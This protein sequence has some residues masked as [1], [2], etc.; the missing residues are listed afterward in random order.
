MDKRLIKQNQEKCNNSIAE[1]EKY[2]Q[3]IILPLQ[4]LKLNDCSTIT[5]CSQFVESHLTVVRHNRGKQ[6]FL[7]YLHRL[8][9]LKEFLKNTKT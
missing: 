9:E 5:N 2:F 6:T 1:L 7:P 8:K 4:P 3:S